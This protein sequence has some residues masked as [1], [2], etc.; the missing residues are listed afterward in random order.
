MPAEDGVFHFAVFGDRTA[1]LPEG[2]A[3][4]AQ[5][6]EETNLMA[7][8]LVMTVGDLVQGYGEREPWL[9]DM[10]EYRSIMERLRMPWFPVAGNHDIYWWRGEA[11][12]GHHE[13]DY[14]A[15]F[16]P[17]WYWFAH[18]NAAF[19]VLYTDEGRT[20]TNERGYRR[21]DL[22]QMGEEQIAWLQDTLAETEDYD[23]VMVFM[24]HPRW[25][26]G[27]YPENNWPAVHDMLVEAGNVSAVFAGHLHRQYYWGPKDGILYYSL[28]T[29]GGGM[30]MDVPGT[31][32]LNHMDLV[33]VRK[34]RIE[35]ASL[36]VGSVLDPKTQTP[37]HMADVERAYRLPI[38]L[39]SGPVE[40]RSDGSA[41]GSAAYRINNTASRTIEVTAS[42][43][44]RA[45][46]WWARQDQA[47]TSIPAGQ[48]KDIAL[49]FRRSPDRFQGPFSVPKVSIQVDYLAAD[50]R[51]SLPA[52]ERVIYLQPAADESS[53][54]A[55]AA[56]V[57]R[58]LR[59]SQ[60]G[61]GLFL[62]PDAFSLPQGPVTL[63]G[64]FRIE[65]DGGEQSL[66]GKAEGSGFILMLQDGRPTFALNFDRRF[67]VLRGG[68]ENKV[69]PGQWHHMA[70]VFDGTAM[71][72]YLDGRRLGSRNAGGHFRGNDLPL[73]IGADPDPEAEPGAGFAGVIDE[74]RI[75]SRA[76]YEGDSF[77]PAARHRADADTLLLLHFDEAAGKFA[78]DASPH[79][80]HAIA[81]GEIGIVEAPTNRPATN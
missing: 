56:A 73:F 38:V 54:N 24:H 81:I 44:V 15:H 6:V 65:R 67:S 74:V 3:I 36:P 78:Y 33:T 9:A 10:R 13:S 60:P 72:L 41:A 26:E 11:E 49:Q 69:K 45:G 8:D 5:A 34:D 75:S 29:I 64:W 7:P 79:G 40:L 55:E 16:G 31:G 52:R 32:W 21:P 23:H 18:K 25:L 14:E 22:Q 62:A 43:T 27:R 61:S 59:L 68:P 63:E 19:I 39:E 77:T 1:G 66:I 46:D 2:V 80:R 70:G 53:E 20:E 42:L 35:I 28:A 51:I 47:S 76:R 12:P 71:H 37:E 30:E 58:A 17:L 48:S 50:R 57:N 4:L